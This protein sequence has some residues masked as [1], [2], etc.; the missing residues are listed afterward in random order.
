MFR[1]KGGIQWVGGRGKL[2]YHGWAWYEKTWDKVMKLLL[3]G[4]VRMDWIIWHDQHL[5]QVAEDSL[6]PKAKYFE[7]KFTRYH[8]KCFGVYAVFRRVLYIHQL[9]NIR[10]KRGVCYRHVTG[11][12]GDGPSSRGVQKYQG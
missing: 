6:L 5:E 11:R 4:Y 3:E 9:K 10:Y 1:V 2:K 7:Q 8:P 12:K